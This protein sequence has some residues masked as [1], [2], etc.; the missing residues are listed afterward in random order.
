MSVHLPALSTSRGEDCRQGAVFHINY[1]T[2][3]ASN[4]QRELRSAPVT[5]DT[6]GIFNCTLIKHTNCSTKCQ[7]SVRDTK[8]ILQ[9]SVP[10]TFF[11]SRTPF[12]F[13][14][15]TTDPHII[16]QV[17]I[18]CPD[19]MNPKLYIYLSELI[20]YSYKYIPVSYIIMRCMI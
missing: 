11:Y 14:K 3:M 17:N 12:W 13:R 5:N 19:D 18:D 6:V 20:L 16:A 8:H 7:C 2:T 1:Q 10:Q 15:I 9:R 4:P